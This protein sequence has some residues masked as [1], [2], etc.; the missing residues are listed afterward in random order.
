MQEYCICFCYI[1]EATCMELTAW[2]SCMPQR[3]SEDLTWDDYAK[4]VGMNLRRL[5]VARGLSQER[6][7]FDAGLSKIQYQRIENGGFKHDPP[8]NPTARTLL[9]L[10]QIL[11]VDDLLP[12][13]WPDLHAK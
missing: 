13:P 4:T 3:V 11:E 8:S 6:V 9:A 5:R 7:A 10:A 1:N 2:L 12:K